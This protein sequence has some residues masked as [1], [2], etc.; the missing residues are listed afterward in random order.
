MPRFKRGRYLNSVVLVGA[1]PRVCPDL[2]GHTGPPLRW[3]VPLDGAH[4]PFSSN[5]TTYKRE[6]ASRVP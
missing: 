2:G 1:D 3:S 5:S 4:A 6:M